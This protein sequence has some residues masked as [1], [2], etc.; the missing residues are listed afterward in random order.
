V[1]AARTTL[2]VMVN[3]EVK[4]SAWLMLSKKG[5]Y[6]YLP[7]RD[8]TFGGLL[9]SGPLNLGIEFG[10]LFPIRPVNHVVPSGGGWRLNL[11]TRARLPCTR[12]AWTASKGIW[13][14]SH[15]R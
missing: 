1:S 3:Q 2:V 4:L 14:P 11:L 15:S 8:L 6:M 7:L 12:F 13:F 10:P 9:A 5:Q